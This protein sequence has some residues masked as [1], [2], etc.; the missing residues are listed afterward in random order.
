MSNLHKTDEE[1]KELEKVLNT[2]DKAWTFESG[3]GYGK[4]NRGFV[5]LQYHNGDG[6]QDEQIEFMKKLVAS[7]QERIKKSKELFPKLYQTLISM[8]WTGDNAKPCIYMTFRTD[9]IKDIVKIFHGV[10]QDFQGSKDDK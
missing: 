5:I 7:V 3:Q 8:E 2:L 6:T 1:I 9:S 10:A 4:D